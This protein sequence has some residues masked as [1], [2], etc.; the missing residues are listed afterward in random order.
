MLG[1]IVICDFCEM[2]IHFLRVLAHEDLCLAI[3]G[4]NVCSIMGATLSLSLTTL[5]VLQTIRMC[6]AIHLVTVLIVLC[7]LHVLYLLAQRDIIG[8]TNTV[9]VL[10]VGQ[11]GVSLV[12]SGTAREVIRNLPE[13]DVLDMTFAGS[14]HHTHS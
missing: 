14:F 8:Y 10:G 3:G 2:V 12:P 5:L 6:K 4:S 1:A 7:L 13:N 11:K 9:E